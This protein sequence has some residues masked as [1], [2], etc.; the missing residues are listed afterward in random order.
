MHH[1][2]LGL[3]IR[4]RLHAL[5]IRGDALLRQFNGATAVAFRPR[6][7]GFRLCQLG[8][9]RLQPRL[10]VGHAAGGRALHGLAGGLRRRNLRA[11][12]INGRR[13]GAGL[14][15]ELGRVEQ[16]DQI[17]LL[18]FGA[19]VHQ[20]FGDTALDLRAHDDLVGVHRADQIQIGAARRR[21]QVVGQRNDEHNG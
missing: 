6:E 16:G 2:L 15:F 10:H 14:G 8:S 9:C 3:Q 12:A 7:G 18:Y 13:R 1:C 20:Q 4:F 11:Q 5:L 17:A 21:K 19:F